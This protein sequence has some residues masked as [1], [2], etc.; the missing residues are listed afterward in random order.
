MP[1]AMTIRDA[2]GRHQQASPAAKTKEA[3][4]KLGQRNEPRK[5][6]TGSTFQLPS[7]NWQLSGGVWLG[8][9]APSACRGGRLKR[10]TPLPGYMRLCRRCCVCITISC[11]PNLRPELILTLSTDRRGTESSTNAGCC[12]DMQ[13]IPERP[14]H[15]QLPIGDREYGRLRFAFFVTVPCIASDGTMCWLAR[16]T[17]VW[18]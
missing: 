16:K 2:S 1:V 3:E 11:W 5:K 8:Q 6:K 17:S 7:K 14:Y 13:S 4:S 10:D 12:R 15:Q 9:K 18:V